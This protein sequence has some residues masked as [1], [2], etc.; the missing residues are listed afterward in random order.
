MNQELIL[1]EDIFSHGK[2]MKKYAS[3]GDIVFLISDCVNCSIVED[4]KGNRFSV[5]NLY[6]KKHDK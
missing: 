4:K 2:G 3:K 5:S 1:L 6:L